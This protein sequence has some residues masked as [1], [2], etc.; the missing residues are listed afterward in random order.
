LNLNGKPGPNGDF[1][2]TRKEFYQFIEKGGI[3]KNGRILVG[4][5]FN[6]TGQ[7]GK[8]QI[9][10]GNPRTGSLTIGEKG[11]KQKNANLPKGKVAS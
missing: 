11:G 1:D 4:T 6:G 9:L 2:F 8:T 5:S 3:P 7:K 10:G